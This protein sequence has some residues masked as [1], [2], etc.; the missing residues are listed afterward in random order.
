MFRLYQLAAIVAII[1]LSG[2]LSA[3]DED[4]VGGEE[5]V[6]ELSILGL[7]GTM[8][9]AQAQV[10]ISNS[11]MDR[12]LNFEGPSTQSITLPVGS[13]QINAAEVAKHISPDYITVTIQADETTRASMSYRLRAGL[14]HQGSDEDNAD[15]RI[16]Q[17]A[18]E[19]S[20]QHMDNTDVLLAS[21]GDL[22]IGVL[23]NDTLVGSPEDDI[24]V[25]GPENFVGPN[26]DVIYGG[27]GDDINIWV[28][29]D[30]SDA[31]IG[32]AGN[33]ISIFAPFK[34]QS[35]P[36]AVPTLSDGNGRP[37]PQVSISNKPQFTCSI[38]AVP[39]SE[40]LGYEFLLRFAVNGDVKV[41][42]RHSEVEAIVCPSDEEGTLLLADLSE[43]TSFSKVSLDHF[44]DTLLGEILRP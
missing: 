8:E 27:A 22:L 10:A 25:G 36:G 16:L 2:M 42:V 3:C 43:G 11:S 26:S 15:N 13:Y 34:N 29:G 14:V 24:L 28:P 12:S 31:V 39:S 9:K 35:A 38:E 41:T 19:T 6:L 20:K 33:D 7:L 5:G 40:G 23:G 30:G 32:G 4:Q 44:A 21:S 37:V 18:D 1:F 17:P